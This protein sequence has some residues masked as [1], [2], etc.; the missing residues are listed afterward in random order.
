MS[1]AYRGLIVMVFSGLIVE[2]D[3][4]ENFAGRFVQYLRGGLHGIFAGEMREVYSAHTVCHREPSDVP[5]RITFDWYT[6]F[7]T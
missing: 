2:L 4:G 7:D 6:V 5:A 3:Q 1:G